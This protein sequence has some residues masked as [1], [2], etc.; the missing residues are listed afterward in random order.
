MSGGGGTQTVGFRYYMG[1]HLVWCMGPVDAFLQLTSGDRVAWAGERYTATTTTVNGKTTTTYTKTSTAPMTTSGQLWIEA[2]DLFGGEEKEGGLQGALDVMMGEPAQGANAYLGA[3]QTG[4][5][6]GYRG[7]LGTVFRQG[8]IGANNPYIKAWA[9]Q[10]RRILRGWQSDAPW[11]SVKAAIDVGGGLLAAN[12]AHIIYECLTNAEWGM[13]YTPGIINDASFRAAADTFH[14]EGLGLCL[15]WLRQDTIDAFVQVVADHAGANLVQ[16]RRTGLFELLPIRADY[17]VDDLL[18][19]NP[20][21]V[22]TLDSYQRPAVPDAVNELT[23]KYVD[24]ATGETGAITVQNLANIAS[25]G[26]VVSAVQQYPGI[27]TAALAQRLGMRDLRSRSA[28]LAR[29]RLQANRAA[30]AVLPGHVVRLT[31]PKRGITNLVLRVLTV[32]PGTLGDGAIQIEA[33]EDVFGLPAATYVAQQGSGWTDPSSLPAVPATRIV[34]EATR[35]ELAREMTADEL[36][37]LPADAGYLLAAAVR[38]SGDAQDFG[39]MTK[40]GSEAYVERGR[41][42]WAPGGRLVGTLA[43]AATAA[44]LTGARDLDLVQPGDLAQIDAEIVRVDAVNTG[45]GAVTLGRGVLGTVAASHAAGA[46]LVFLG[47]YSATDGV[48]RIDGETVSAK[49]LT[50]TGRGELALADAPADSV[51][52]DSL[53]A[54]P[55]APGRLRINGQAYPAELTTFPIAV[56]WA[57]RD[58]LAQ[59][60]EGDESGNIG[61]EVGTSYAGRLVS[62]STGAVVTSASGMTGTA[63]SIASAPAGGRYRLELWSVRAGLESAQRHAAVFDLSAFIDVTAPG[64]DITVAASIVT[65]TAGTTLSPALLQAAATARPEQERW[66]SYQLAPNSAGQ[67]VV[68]PAATYEIHFQ[69]PAS[70]GGTVDVPVAVLGSSVGDEMSLHHAMVSAFNSKPAL[71]ASGYSMEVNTFPVPGVG[72]GTTLYVRGP[73]G[74][75]TWAGPS[76][77]WLE[78]IFAP[79]AA[80]VP[81]DLPQITDVTVG[82]S[83]AAGDLCAITV[84]A[85]TY[86]HIAQ[87]GATTGSIAAALATLVDAS[88]TY[89]ATVVGSKVRV[90]GPTKVS[91]AASAGV[92]GGVAWVSDSTGWLSAGS[93]L[94]ALAPNGSTI[95]AVDAGQMLPDT[96]T[97]GRL[98]SSTDGGATWSVAYTGADIPAPLSGVWSAD[99]YLG[100][101]RVSL[102]QN[103]DSDVYTATRATAPGTFTVTSPG[104]QVGGVTIV[105]GGTGTDGSTAYIVGRLDD[106]ATHGPINLY[107]STDGAAWALVGQLE[108]DPADTAPTG[109]RAALTAE[110]FVPSPTST[111]YRSHCQLKR[112]GSRWFLIGAHSIWATDAATPRTGW[113]RMVLGLND[114]AFSPPPMVK[115][116]DLVGSTLVAWLANAGGNIVATSTD[117]GATWAASRP[118]VLGAWEELRQGWVYGGQL[119]ILCN[120]NGSSEANQIV[121]TSTPAGAWTRTTTTGL[122]AVM[123]GPYTAGSAVVCTDGA[124][125]PRLMRSTD[126]KTFSAV[127]LP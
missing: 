111:T 122:S 127:S 49:L 47:G 41:G 126:G 71:A 70:G 43:P 51:T 31:W 86:T 84:G 63:W 83:P 22:L 72:F 52:C 34:R 114:E 24:A 107:S 59:N 54:R 81:A 79:G 40:T 36:A 9:G 69:V 45:T 37:A 80:A 20:S 95:Y 33:V 53:A 60:L 77:A 46:W 6:P 87:A 13:G 103:V 116:L 26:G 10:F 125:A 78:S 1:L 121:S 62:D 124:T 117:S 11:Y 76:G 15:A 88:A 32:S 98:Y 7:L 85:E 82:G 68:D 65:R 106:L 25:Q 23:I 38:P 74:L 104:P 27:P 57:H 30:W 73:F 39:L 75:Y 2:P 97:K 93:Q 14:G 66:V 21:N 119:H 56:S 50:R 96:S 92:T 94:R 91:F 55:Y 61:P 113:R 99:V 100:S 8:L 101:T 29:V 48:Q 58:R 3:V 123:S 102:G 28:P 17:D 109:G 64:G 18:Q 19:L 118:A 5:Q 108:R 42:P 110:W 120:G 90:T 105:A 12:P 112:L 67:I 89:A 16:N 44:T 35:F 115:G 4:P